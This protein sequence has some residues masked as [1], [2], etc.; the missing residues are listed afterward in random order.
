VTDA[1]LSSTTERITIMTV[2][3]KNLLEDGF[4]IYMMKTVVNRENDTITLLDRLAA[5][6]FIVA[7]LAQETSGYTIGR[8]SARQR[9][10]VWMD[11]WGGKTDSMRQ[12][13]EV[14]TQGKEILQAVVNSEVKNPTMWLR[15]GV[16]V[17]VAVVICVLAAKAFGH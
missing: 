7:N 15:I 11:F 13:L 1:D 8:E 16:Y 6:Y 4:E 10:T 14:R 9:M 12:Y 2:Y 17:I 3:P 5:G